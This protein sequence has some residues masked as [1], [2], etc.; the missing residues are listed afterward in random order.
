M[1]SDTRKLIEST[2]SDQSHPEVQFSNV[3]EEKLQKLFVNNREHS[4]STIH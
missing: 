4:Y 1:K 3:A 2:L